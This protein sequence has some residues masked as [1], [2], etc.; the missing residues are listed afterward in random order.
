MLLGEDGG[1]IMIGK[2][3]KRVNLQERCLFCDYFFFQLDKLIF[4]SL[5]RGRKE[6]RFT[7]GID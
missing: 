1:E 7:C 5:G 6:E 4:F 3:Y 2:R